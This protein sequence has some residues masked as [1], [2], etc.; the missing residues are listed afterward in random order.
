M[1]GGFTPSSHF[2]AVSSP[3]PGPL[4]GR[5]G[6][7]LAR[8]TAGAREM[9]LRPSAPC[10]AIASPSKIGLSLRTERN[11]A[12]LFRECRELAETSFVPP[13]TL[14]QARSASSPSPGLKPGAIICRLSEAPSRRGCQRNRRVISSTSLRL[15]LFLRRCLACL[16]A[17]KG[18]GDGA[19]FPFGDGGGDLRDDLGLG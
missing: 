6:F 4:P 18:G 3:H 17:F 19:Y 16:R 13:G 11:G 9:T 5:K 10:G 1:R 14:M 7:E 8:C 15:L 2:V 12:G